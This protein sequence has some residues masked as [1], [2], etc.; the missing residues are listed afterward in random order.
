M[1]GISPHAMNKHLSTVMNLQI[2]RVGDGGTLTSKWTSVVMVE[3]G[4]VAT[5]GDTL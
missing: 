1:S 5:E 3:E 4:K 2:G